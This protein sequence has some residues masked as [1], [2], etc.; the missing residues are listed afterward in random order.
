MAYILNEK[1]PFSN[2][3]VCDIVSETFVLITRNFPW[4]PTRPHRD[5]DHTGSLDVD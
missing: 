1:V 5:V 3:T 2:H 4:D